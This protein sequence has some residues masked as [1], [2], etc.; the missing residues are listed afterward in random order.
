MG[1]SPQEIIMAQQELFQRRLREVE[2][3]ACPD[4]YAA[5]QQLIA[6]S[7]RLL[8]LAKDPEHYANDPEL[9]VLETQME[10]IARRMAS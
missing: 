9:V 4:A 10:A 3:R 6:L 7:R 8:A 5:I 2:Q 1:M